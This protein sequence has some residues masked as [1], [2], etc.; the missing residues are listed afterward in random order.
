[1]FC[2]VCLSRK[3]RDKL[4]PAD[5]FTY[6]CQECMEISDILRSVYGKKYK[7]WKKEKGGLIP[8]QKKHTR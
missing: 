7:Q 3:P 1:M 4:F 5:A 2:T 6:I 8:C